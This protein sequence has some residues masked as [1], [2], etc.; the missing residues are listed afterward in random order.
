MMCLE[1]VISNTTESNLYGAPK[2]TCR[3][4]ILCRAHDLL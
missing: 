4:N 3:W 1:A 2:G